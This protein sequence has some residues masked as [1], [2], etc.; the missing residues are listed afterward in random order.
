MK[1]ETIFT[2]VL[3]HDDLSALKDG[4]L[5]GNYD[6]ISRGLGKYL[7]CIPD[8]NSNPCIHAFGNER[9][10]N[11]RLRAVVTPVSY[12]R[13][14]AAGGFCGIVAQYKHHLDYL[15][16]VLDRDGHVKLLQRTAGGF[17]LLASAALEFCI[18]QSLSLTISIQGGEIVGTAGP[19]SG[20]TT[21][22]AQLPNAGSGKTGFICTA[23]ARFGPH[24]I[25][26]AP[27]EAARIEKAIG[28]AKE[29]SAKKRAKFPRMK[30]ER[31]VPLHGLSTSHNIIF[32]DINDDGKLEILLGQSSE[33]VARNV[34]LTK[35]TCLTALD[36]EG[37]ILWQAGVPDPDVK[38]AGWGTLPFRFHDLFGDGHPVVVCV[39][40]YDI[41][42]RHAKTGK[43]IMSA[44]TPATRPVSDDFK[45]V[46]GEIG[47]W[48]DETLNMNVS[49]ID[50]CDTQGNG[51]KKEILVGDWFNLAVLDPL[52]EPTLH[53]L[54]THR[55]ELRGDAWI[56][57]IDGDG[58]DEIFAGSSLLD[59]D[60]SLIGSVKLGAFG[61]SIRVLDPLDETGENKR[62]I[63]S[64]ALEGL[65][66]FDLDSLRKGE[67]QGGTWGAFRVRSC[68]PESIS[69]GKFRSDLPGIQFAAT[70]DPSVTLFD[71]NMHKIWSREF[72]ARDGG[73]RAVNWTG[74]P[75]N[76][77][78]ISMGLN[79]GLI[80]GYGDIVV[81]APE[82][83]PED[84]CDVIKGYC[85][86]G[87]DAIAAWNSDEL[88]IYVPDS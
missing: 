43:V 74:K 1:D 47:R 73:A 83:G 20:K 50:F 14:Q 60:G 8:T 84:H 77:M 53:P 52:A 69:S 30:L 56:G 88:A 62:V 21:I 46:V 34:S 79:C 54:F 37:K 59:N 2:H 57:D 71:A 18:G 80:D 78:L 9:W 58:K 48:G 63:V 7:D 41:Q 42:I 22:R 49:W 5:D 61:N 15:A 26:C 4:P 85:A 66:I 13:C 16:F 75:E 82:A 68:A 65:S 72:D 28:D 11:Y 38:L 24:T 10:S 51:A 35:L 12:E 23:P 27:D 31:T 17:E 29:A 36:L 19:Y 76:L 45:A 86:D 3:Y 81:E 55:G 70:G 87:R 6:I 67:Y 44:Q 39:F 64:A 32:G 33:K 40:G 25:E